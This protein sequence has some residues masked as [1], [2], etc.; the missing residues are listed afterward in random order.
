MREI[1]FPYKDKSFDGVFG[2]GIRKN[3]FD[4]KYKAE[5]SSIYDNIYPANLCFDGDASTFCHTRNDDNLQYLQIH[6][7]NIVFKI[8]GFTIKNRNENF[9]DPL[10][11]SIQGSNDGESFTTINNFSD[12]SNEV[13]GAGVIRSRQVYPLKRYNYFRLKKI[14]LPC[15][16]SGSQT[17]F[18]IG[19]FELFGTFYLDECGS[20]IRKSIPISCI[21]NLIYIFVI[22]S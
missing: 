2:N 21:I 3:N 6:F 12:A 18:N 16:S 13:C 4:I 17:Y 22:A 11:Y 10:K 5:L 20:I 19:E 9:W 8:E 14:G 15:Y 7:L 1:R